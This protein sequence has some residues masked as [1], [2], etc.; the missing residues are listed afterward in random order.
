MIPT[1]TE[2]DLEPWLGASG[3]ERFSTLDTLQ[4]YFEPENLKAI[5]GPGC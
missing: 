2:I 5:L 1:Y 4:G 3:V